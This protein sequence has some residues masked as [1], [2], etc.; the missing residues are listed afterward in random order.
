MEHK[1]QT[2]RRRRYA[3]TKNSNKKTNR[4]RRKAVFRS[5]ITNHVTHVVDKKEPMNVTLDVN[6]L[7]DEKKRVVSQLRKSSTI[8]MVDSHFKLA[9]T[10][11]K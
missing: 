10:L 5:T 8:L 11:Q 2:V 6:Q 3:L 9:F 4:K 1:T 7:I